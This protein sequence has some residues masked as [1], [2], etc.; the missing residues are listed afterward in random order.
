MVKLKVSF[1][2]SWGELNETN[3]GWR[4]KVAGEN[5]LSKNGSFKPK[6]LIMF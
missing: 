2:K 5:W 3:N 1:D 4:M 6:I